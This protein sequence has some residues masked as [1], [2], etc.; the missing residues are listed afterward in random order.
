DEETTELISRKFEEASPEVPGGT[1]RRG[2]LRG[3]GT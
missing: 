3:R 2:G 1:V